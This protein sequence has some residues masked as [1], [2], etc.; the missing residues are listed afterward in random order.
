[1]KFNQKKT[2]VALFLCLIGSGCSTLQ[3]D[4]KGGDYRTSG[5]GSDEV[6]QCA[7]QVRSI[8]SSRVSQSGA[9]PGPTKPAIDL[10]YWCNKAA[11]KGD[12]KSQLVL[13]S[14]YERGIGV[15][16][17]QQE[18]LR[19]YKASANSG[20]PEAQFRVGQIYGRGEGVPVDRNEAT[21]WYIKAAEQ[22]HAEAQYYMGYRYEHGKGIAQNYGEAVR[23]Y[24]KAAE[25][26]NVSAM[27]GLGALNLLGHGV[28][29]NQLEA[30]KWFNLAAVSGE[31]EFIANRD[32]V[33]AKLTATQL[34][35]GQRLASEWARTH[36]IG[37]AAS[38]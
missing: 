21:R 34:A 9:G 24:G 26:G 37:K 11:E 23:W 2:H 6:A 38:D 14:L 29:Q 12:A 33:A 31:R 36:S 28:P 7:S 5:N 20:Y 8:N 3:P 35:E 19:W 17:S 32:K 18:A 15:P 16:A 10:L 13:A 27:N 25:Q 30:Y 22:G 4:L 1:V